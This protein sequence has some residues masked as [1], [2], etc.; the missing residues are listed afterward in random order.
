MLPD[1]IIIG[2][3]KGGTT[4]LYHYLASHPDVVASRDKETDF[5]RSRKHFSKGIE[6]YRQQ[7]R[8]AGT[9]ALEA[10]PNYTKR[11]KFRGVPRR[12]HSVL[13]EAKLVYVLRDPVERIIS[14]YMHNRHHGRETRRQGVKLIPW[15]NIADHS[16]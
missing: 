8:G 13:P 12:M 15:V 10:S 11:H 4:S 2:A 6:W 1:I 14:H 7:F 9:H 5:F 3:M 16:W